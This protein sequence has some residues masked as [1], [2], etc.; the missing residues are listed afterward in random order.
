MC[1]GCGHQHDYPAPP[2]LIRKDLIAAL[3]DEGQDALPPAVNDRL[4]V[5]EQPFFTPIY[6]FIAPRIVSGRVALLGDAA[7]NAPRT[8]VRRIQGGL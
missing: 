6:D 5:I 4:R 1:D 8:W 7:S 2:P 3:R